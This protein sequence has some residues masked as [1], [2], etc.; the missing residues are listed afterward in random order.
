MVTET[1]IATAIFPD[2]NGMKVVHPFA[3]LEALGEFRILRVGGRVET[4]E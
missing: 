4:E 3:A 1:A 2:T